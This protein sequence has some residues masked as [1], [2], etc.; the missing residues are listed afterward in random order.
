MEEI[1]LN[2][3]GPLAC[4]DEINPEQSIFVKEEYANKAGIY[5]W[6]YM[7]N[8][9]YYINYVGQTMHLGDRI[10]DEIKDVLIGKCSFVYNNK[11]GIKVYD[12]IAGFLAF[13]KNYK[14]ISTKMFEFIIKSKIYFAP[15]DEKNIK[16][17]KKIESAFISKLMCLYRDQEEEKLLTNC[18]ISRYG[19]G[20]LTVKSNWANVKP[21]PFLAD[22]LEYIVY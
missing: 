12:S 14:D 6:T 15:I 4:F 13:L 3:Q 19:D 16:Q 22:K 7:F 5:L 11:E 9:N 10:S 20:D 17:T 21:I 1:T 8:D 2:W 18:G